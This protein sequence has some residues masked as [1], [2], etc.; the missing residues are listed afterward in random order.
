MTLL[1]IIMLCILLF[2][3]GWWSG[4]NFMKCDSQILRAEIEMLKEDILNVAD[5]RPYK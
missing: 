4:T 2:L 3:I 1:I 5:G